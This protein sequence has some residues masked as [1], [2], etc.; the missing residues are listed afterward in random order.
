MIRGT[1]SLA[2]VVHCALLLATASTSVSTV[3]ASEPGFAAPIAAV[4]SPRET[5]S[6]S[7]ALLQQSA[8]LA[9]DDDSRESSV[10]ESPWLWAGVAGVIA[11]G[12]VLALAM[13][14]SD[15][16]P[17]VPPGTL[18]KSVSVLTKEPCGTASERPWR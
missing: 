9:S 6:A 8:V 18:S 5:A 1:A 10:F 13:S 4:P 2:R 15:E 3:H 14:S 16:E 12:V 7:P 11:A 17:S